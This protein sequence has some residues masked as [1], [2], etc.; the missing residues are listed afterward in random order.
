MELHCFNTYGQQVY[1]EE[2]TSTESVINI[3]TWQA[4]IY[5]AVIYA[6][7]KPVGQSKF[8]VR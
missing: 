8:V 3:S 5:L 7:G 4:G 6:H 2:I 1:Q